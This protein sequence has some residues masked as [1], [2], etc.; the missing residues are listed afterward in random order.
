MTPKPHA[1][2]GPVRSTRITKRVRAPK[3]ANETPE[4]ARKRALDRDA[5]RSFREKTKNYIAHLEQTV[6]A[7]KAESNSQLVSQLL[8]EN[9]ELYSTVERLRKIISDIYTATQ[10]EI[11][12]RNRAPDDSFSSVKDDNKRDDDKPGQ[13]IAVVK[14]TVSPLE[15]MTDAPDATTIDVVPHAVAAS[16]GAD[17]EVFSNFLFTSATD[18]FEQY[19]AD[20]DEAGHLP[21]LHDVF[22]SSDELELMIDAPVPVADDLIAFPVDVTLACGNSEGQDLVTKAGDLLTQNAQLVSDRT[23]T[24]EQ[25][26]Q[27][28]RSP[29]AREGCFDL[30]VQSPISF[31]TDTIFPFNLWMQTNSVYSQ[32][33]AISPRHASE[34]RNS[35]SG[36]LFKAIENGWSSLSYKE[37]RNPVIQIL[38]CYDELVSKCLNRVNRLAIAYKN[39]LLIK[40]QRI[41]T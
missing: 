14:S 36:V 34:A 39:H 40:V 19:N 28:P 29:L 3:E 33:F 37:Q 4:R 22:V 31:F 16:D 35:D 11:S 32:I 26:K 17:H 6:A 7:C 21:S 12:E 25:C 24:V 9:A 13:A 20:M 30:S 27:P 18:S 15:V 41:P 8:A 38:R 10:P 23:M 5:Q 2:A 1:K